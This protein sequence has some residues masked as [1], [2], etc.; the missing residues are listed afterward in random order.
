MEVK[1][2]STHIEIKD[3]DSVQ[4]IVTGYLANFGSEDSD[5]DIIDPGAFTKSI[6][7]NGPTGKGFIKYL[8]DHNTKN[9]V[10]VFTTLKEDNVGLYYEAKIGRHTAG[11]DYL[12]MVEDGIINQHSIGFSRIKQE[13]KEKVKYIKEV[14]LF[15][16]SG[17]QFW[18]SNGNTPI[19]GIKEMN[20]IVDRLT[21]LNKALRDGAYTDDGFKAIETEINIINESLKAIKAADSTLEVDEPNILTGLI[22]VLSHN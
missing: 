21:I 16:G 1:A 20:D 22:N 19:T 11:R 15:E 13:V 7:E 5:G 14:R 8:L 12:M 4:G 18:A 17:L 2:F 6:N 10:G 3:A 9:S